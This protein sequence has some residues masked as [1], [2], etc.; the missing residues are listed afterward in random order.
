MG[1]KKKFKE[2]DLLVD[3]LDVSLFDEHSETDEDG[4]QLSRYTY[5]EYVYARMRKTDESG[6]VSDRYVIVFGKDDNL[7]AL[8]VISET[9]VFVIF[10]AIKKYKVKEKKNV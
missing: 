3:A 10:N 5:N 8:E 6:V 7:F 2:L 9:A 4:V 1:R